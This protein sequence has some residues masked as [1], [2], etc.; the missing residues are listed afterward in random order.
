MKKII[1]VWSAILLLSS[2]GTEIENTNTWNTTSTS[3]VLINN[4]DRNVEIINLQPEY[5]AEL[6]GKV[7]S[8]EWNVFTISEI[9]TSK[10]PTINMES[11]EKQAYMQSLSEADRLA[12]KDMI[13][14]SIVWDIKVMIPVWIPM[15]KKEL[16]WEEKQDIEA[17]LEDLKSWDIVS[18]WYNTEITDRKIASYVKRSIRK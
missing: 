10:D 18:I 11:S 2:C 7:K 6:Y 5:K 13:A 1:I 17:T 12:L 14:S 16:I 9:D 4:E 15:I 8:I 3:N